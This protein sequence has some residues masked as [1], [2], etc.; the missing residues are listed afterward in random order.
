M[1]PP[2]NSDAYSP[3]VTE[4]IAIRAQKSAREKILR[5][6][7]VGGVLTWFGV[8]I[9]FPIYGIV[10]E[11][12]KNGLSVFFSSLTTPE[13]LHAFWLTALTTIVAVVINTF[14][15]VIMAIVFS[16]QDF[17]GKLFM[18]SLLDLPFAISPVVAGFMFVVLF[19]PNGWIGKL[20]ESANIKIVY[21]LPG[22]MI[23]T[24]FVTLPFTA[25]EII[26]ILREF[27]RD[28][29]EAA[30]T[31][32]ASPWKTFRSVTLPS[33]KWGLAYG[34]TLTIARSIGEFGAVM[35]VSGSIIN[36]T[37]TAT[38]FIHAQYTDF[39]YAG[40]F[41]AA[42]VLAILSF[43]ILIFIQLFYK[44]KEAERANAQTGTDTIED[45]G[46]LS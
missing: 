9:L 3:A 14:L 36:H 24:V 13:A 22:M 4:I 10:T 1:N 25:R 2:S 21:A 31:L 32:G 29:E 16:R 46:E 5:G 42:L 17:K 23:A 30:A 33:I 39:N 8:L 37:Q 7:L 40:A 43:V 12:L 41:A 15:G 20:F 34:I 11:A 35:V 38:L 45:I 6:L 26:P 18:E 19:G 28:E 44:K 27:G